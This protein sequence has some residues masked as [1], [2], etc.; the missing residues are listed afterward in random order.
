[1]ITTDEEVGGF[2]G[3]KFLVEKVK[4]SP[5]ALIVPDGGD[6]LVFVDKAKR[7]LSNKYSFNEVLLLMRA[8]PG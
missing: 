7:R 4:F 8:G 3:A 1:M 2:E 5:K 6:N